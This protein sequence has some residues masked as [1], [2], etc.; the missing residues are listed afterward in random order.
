MR[1]LAL[2]VSAA[3]LLIGVAWGM[4]TTPRVDGPMAGATAGIALPP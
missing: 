3:F 2:T 1:R 4:T